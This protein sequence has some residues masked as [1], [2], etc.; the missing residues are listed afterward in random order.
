MPRLEGHTIV[1]TGAARGLGL[2]L[3]RDLAARGARLVLVDAL[4]D[5]GEA[6]AASLRRAG[7]K[8]RY[9]RAD[10]ADPSSIRA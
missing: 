5:E 7:A 8:A 2:V 3:A 4:S 10:L 1:V 9:A 6:A